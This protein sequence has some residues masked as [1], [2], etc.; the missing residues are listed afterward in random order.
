M[1]R[2]KR[3]YSRFASGFRRRFSGFRQKK[4]FGMK[5][6]WWALIFLGVTAFL[7]FVLQNIAK[8]NNVKLG[9]LIKDNSKKTGG[10]I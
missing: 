1:K 6:Q 3:F 9:D 7:V 4:V 2:R 10:K 8:K 5:V